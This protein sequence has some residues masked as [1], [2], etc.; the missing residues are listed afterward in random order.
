MKLRRITIQN[1][2]SFRESAEFLSDGPISIAIGPNGGGKTN[3]LDTITI[4]LRKHLLA[5]AY[6]VLQAI[7]EHP[8][9]HVFQYN[10]VLDSLTLAPHSKGGVL[11]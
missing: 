10:N 8:N 11:D 2:R 5:T 4:M 9:R 6:P 7:P 1:V 3:L